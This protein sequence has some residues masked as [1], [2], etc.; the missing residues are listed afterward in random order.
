MLLDIQIKENADPTRHSTATVQLFGSLDT[1]TAPE[2][3]RALAPVLDARVSDLV[4]D[5]AGL[6]FISSAGLRVFG[7]ARKRLKEHGG[8][9]AFVHMQPQI[10]EVFEII[11]AL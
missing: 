9:V 3:E 4:F 8:Q 7:L 5:L 2:L 10:E 1:A 11:K 6:S